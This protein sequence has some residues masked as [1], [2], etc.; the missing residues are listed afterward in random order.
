M[1]TSEKEFIALSLLGMCGKMISGSKSGYCQRNPRNLAI[2]NAN[3]CTQTEKIWFGDL[4][5]TL[6]KQVLSQLAQKLNE[7]IY[8]LYEMDGRFENE[9]SPLV[10]R[11]VVNF[12]SEGNMKLGSSYAF[13]LE[14]NRYD[15]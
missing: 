14:E 1:K 7:D 8:V 15:L 11:H 3:V 5:V 6:S 9:Q 13:L 10:N 12:T 4:D 2:F